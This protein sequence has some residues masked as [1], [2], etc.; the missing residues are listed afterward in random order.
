MAWIFILLLVHSLCSHVLALDGSSYCRYPNLGAHPSPFDHTPINVDE[1][2]INCL[3]YP[4][5][6][7]T[8]QDNTLIV[9]DCSNA[10]YQ[11][12]SAS[13][14][15]WEAYKQP[16][17]LAEGQS[18][19]VRCDDSRPILLVNPPTF[20]SINDG[21]LP[22]PNPSVFV[23]MID[24]VSFEVIN[25]NMPNTLKTMKDLGLDVYEFNKYSTV[26]LN[27]NP[28]KFALFGRYNYDEYQTLENKDVKLS[29]LWEHAKELG[30]TTMIAEDECPRHDSVWHMMNVPTEPSKP[31]ETSPD[32]VML[33]QLCVQDPHPNKY[34]IKDRWGFEYVV[35][36]VSSALSGL[37]ENKSDKPVFMWSNFIDAHEPGQWATSVMD[38][39]VSNYL[40]N[41]ALSKFMDNGVIVFVSDH[42][43][44]FGDFAYSSILG[45]AENKH[46][47]LYVMAKK[48]VLD[49]DIMSKNQ[50]K[51]VTPTDLYRSMASLIGHV[52][53]EKLNVQ[54]IDIFSNE[55][56]ADRTCDMAGIPAEYCLCSYGPQTC[57]QQD[58]P[59]H[60][61]QKCV[62]MYA[63]PRIFDWTYYNEQQLKPRYGKDFTECEAVNH[64]CS[65]GM[66]LGW[67][68]TSV[69]NLRDYVARTPAIAEE[70]W[71][72]PTDCNWG[73]VVEYYFTSGF[74]A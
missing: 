35:D 51:L 26:G 53:V 67:N 44:H 49:H 13:A 66:S 52:D 3:Q 7:A 64:W 34:C 59:L 15:T 17:K 71:V 2:N 58:L 4:S 41:I 16:V 29:W 37:E 19:Q 8:I 56:P 27:S 55:V 24:A 57:P 12:N 42:G 6:N 38:D 50:D 47:F 74:S 72:W 54:D 22:S 5:F 21:R 36:Y 25:R 14:T 46:P 40:R 69:S 32:F 31:T 23:V 43:I 10:E 30:Y 1:Y 18:V 60:L 63:H 28:N 73:A 33:S 20:A 61:W 11:F 45:S 39:S 65:R 70:C 68:G 48:G 9:H 62:S